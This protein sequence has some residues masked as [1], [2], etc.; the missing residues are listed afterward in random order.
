MITSGGQ[1]ARPLVELVQAAAA[2][3]VRLDTSHAADGAPL[4]GVVLGSGLGAWGDG[5]ES[6]VKVPYGEI[7]HMPRSTVVGHAG[8][9]CLGRAGGVPVACLQGRVHLYEGHEP[10]RVVF[11][12]RL[13]ATLGCRAVLLTNAAGGVDAAFSPGDLMVIT[14]HLNLTGKSPLIGPNLDSLGPRFPDMTEAYDTA[15]RQAALEASV[16][17]DVPLQQGVY[18][19]LL[20]PTYET[21]AEIRMLRGLGASAVGM[22]TVPEVIAL[23]H[24]GVRA[25]AISC[26]TN[27]AAG[28]SPTKLD[29]AEVEATAVRTRDRFT[30][31]L[32]AWVRR[33]A[34]I[35]AA[36]GEGR[37]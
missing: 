17:T 2:V 31:L 36:Q 3:R 19:A 28:L 12:V 34:A 11:G 13:L 26:I 5:L 4:V 23:R 8:N 27:L 35:V 37:A 30:K 33:S 22:S 18:A 24:M 25:A 10:E 16:E 7:P 14:D 32:T 20:G 15:L 21:P 6:L 29:H 9:L 1:E